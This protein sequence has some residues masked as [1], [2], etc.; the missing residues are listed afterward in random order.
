MIEQLTLPARSLFPDRLLVPVYAERRHMKSIIFATT[1]IGVG[2]VGA[3]SA[4]P[5]PV[6]LKLD[7]EINISFPDPAHGL[8]LTW[9][10][11]ADSRCPTDAVCV[12]AGEVELT[13]AV[14]PAG[15]EGAELILRLPARDGVETSGRIDGYTIRLDWV[16]PE[17][18]LEVPPTQETY[19]SHL[20]VAPPGTLLPRSATAIGDRS[21]GELK[22]APAIGH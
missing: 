13:L 3:V 2:L 19:F 5:V 18:S 11:I 21:W 12:W 20:T 8:S 6:E 17:A 7:R 16:T 9:T 15:G 22:L 10:Q 1:L 14:V 4:Q